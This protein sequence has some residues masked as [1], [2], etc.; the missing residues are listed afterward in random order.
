MNVRGD[1]GQARPRWLGRSLPRVE[2]RRLV[3]GA[4]AYVDDHLPDGC[5]HLE[6]VRSAYPHGRLGPLELEE[7]RSAE[8][9]VAVFCAA[10][11]GELGQ[12]A[13]NI[14]L[15]DMTARPLRLLA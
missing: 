7:A 8:G 5:L 6:F 2:D 9:V 13:V 4:G 10:D 11:L 15:P 14:V 3:T 12:T 1:I